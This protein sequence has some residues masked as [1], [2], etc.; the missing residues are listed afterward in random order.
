MICVPSLVS[1]ARF[2][3]QK[4]HS[5]SSRS[6]SPSS[7][8]SW[9]SAYTS[10]SSSFPIN[11]SSHHSPGAPGTYSLRMNNWLNADYSTPCVL[12][13]RYQ[14]HAVRKSFAKYKWPERLIGRPDD[15]FIR[16]SPTTGPLLFNFLFCFTLFSSSWPIAMPRRWSCFRKLQPL[17]LISLRTFS[18]ALYQHQTFIWCVENPLSNF[19][20][21]LLHLDIGH[22]TASWTPIDGMT[23]AGSRKPSYEKRKLMTEGR[24]T[25]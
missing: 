17:G 7:L 10:L 25:A 13:P 9:I 20:A 23:G 19:W 22:A 3:N 1:I 11:S 16:D 5:T 4:K 2:S 6:Q 24:G 15:L 12:A 21:P 18:P 14:V 8:P